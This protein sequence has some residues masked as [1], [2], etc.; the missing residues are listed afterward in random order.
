MYVD[1]WPGSPRSRDGQL[2][3]FSGNPDRLYGAIN[4]HCVLPLIFRRACLCTIRLSNRDHPVCVCVCVGGGGGGGMVS[5]STYR[6]PTAI[7][8]AGN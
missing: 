2:K 4:L 8:A 1:T 5:T 3:A 6:F 7:V